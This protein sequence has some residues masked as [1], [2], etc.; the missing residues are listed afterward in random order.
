MDPV[1]NFAKCVVSAGYDAD[2]VTIALTSGEGAKLPQPSTDGAFNL[3]WYNASDYGDPADDP[4]KEIVRVTARSTDTLT[5]TRAQE[6][7]SAATHNT[8]G[9]TYKMILALTKYTY[10]QIPRYYE[11]VLSG[12]TGSVDITVAGASATTIA[13]AMW[14]YNPELD[15]ATDYGTPQG[16]LFISTLAT[17]TVTVEANADQ[18]AD[19]RVVLIIWKL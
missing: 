19:R 10:D 12:A 14:G 2:D 7:T 15:S 16:E 1:K 18:D 8:S 13:S 4:S 5:V 11:G 9:K 6:G 17:N 3:V